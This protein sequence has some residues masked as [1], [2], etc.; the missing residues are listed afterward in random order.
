MTRYSVAWGANIRLS[1]LAGFSDVHRMLSGRKWYKPKTEI[2]VNHAAATLHTSLHHF[3]CHFC[4]AASVA[5]PGPHGLVLV[6]SVPSPRSDRRSHSSQPGDA[7]PQ[8]FSSHFRACD[9]YFFFSFSSSF[10]SWAY[11]GRGT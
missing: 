7:K 11:F 9:F 3:C 2:A 10:D 4:V 6:S 1:L 5:A 8:A